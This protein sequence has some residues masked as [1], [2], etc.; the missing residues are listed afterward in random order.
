MSRFATSLFAAVLVASAIAC[1]ASD[2]GWPP[3]Q[4]NFDLVPVPISTEIVVGPNRMLF[5]ILDSAT[6]QSVASPDV[7]VELRF[8]DLGTSKT[9]AVTTTAGTFMPTVEGRPGLY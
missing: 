7:P 6:N 3:E 2:P 8:F 4:T 5:N 1:Q 9:Q